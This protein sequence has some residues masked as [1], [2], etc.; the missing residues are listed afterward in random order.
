VE[1]PWSG[2]GALHNCLGERT[3]WAALGRQAYILH[4]PSS[5][6]A[7]L[8]RLRNGREDLW[9]LEAIHAAAHSPVSADTVR[10]IVEKLAAVG[11]L[12]PARF[13]ESALVRRV[14]RFIGIVEYDFWDTIEDYAR[15][16]VIGEVA[17]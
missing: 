1:Q 12:I 14:A 3:A 6:V 10:A 4:A 2:L 11:I 17:A 5:A 15:E 9:A 16:R 13:T 7:E 8:V